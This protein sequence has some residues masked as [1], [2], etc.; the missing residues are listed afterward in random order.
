MLPLCR[1]KEL[2]N[3]NSRFLWI[4]FIFSAFRSLQCIG[5]LPSY[6]LRFSLQTCREIAT[7]W[8]RFDLFLMFI[9]GWD[10]AEDFSVWLAEFPPLKL[11]F[12]L[13]VQAEASFTFAETALTNASRTSWATGH[14]P[15]VKKIMC[16]LA[17]L[18]MKTG[19]I[20]M[21]FH[22]LLRS[23]L[24]HSTGAMV[25]ALSTLVSRAPTS[26]LW[27]T[28]KQLTL[29]KLILPL[30]LLLLVFTRSNWH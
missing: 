4:T 30:L 9:S 22:L 3:R 19:V 17:R 26:S 29:A 13:M 21:C 27:R 6:S 25:R 2:H 5:Q 23:H 8:E 15:A 16:R 7:V 24:G 10:N 28:G 1:G 12:D 14:H 20:R 11:D 18:V